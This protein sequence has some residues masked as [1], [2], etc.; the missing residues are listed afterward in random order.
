MNY[1]ANQHRPKA[2]LFF[3]VLACGGVAS[4][5]DWPQWRGPH[6]DGIAAGFT[7]P[8]R[9]QRT[10]ER[11]GKCRSATASPLP[12]GRLTGSTSLAAGR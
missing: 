3:V 2:I 7:A 6:R 9:A 1:R 11:N 12:R 8:A 4:A 10:H 5:Q